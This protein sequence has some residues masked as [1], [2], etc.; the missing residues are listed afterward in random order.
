MWMV[1]CNANDMAAMW[2]YEGLRSMR[3]RPLELVTAQAL[4]YSTHWEHRLGSEGLSVRVGLPD[5]RWL[6][7]DGCNGVVNRLLA[8]PLDLVQRAV[9]GDRDYAMQ[10]NSAFYMSWLYALPHPVMNRPTPQGLCGQWRHPSEWAML[11]AQAGLPVTPWEQ[12]G[13]DTEDRSYTTVAPQGAAVRSTIVAD[14]K[15][16]GAPAPEEITRGCEKLSELCGTPLM[17]VDFYSSPQHT[18][19]FA[20][21]T[22]NPDL[23]SGGWPLVETIAQVLRKGGAR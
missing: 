21:A 14:G 1:L 3:L 2:L 16:F 18:W 11:A 4:A 9:P 13:Q 7:S 15:T 6:A 12:S 10:E 8:A 17:G 20:G 23:R 19:T 5:G 22:P